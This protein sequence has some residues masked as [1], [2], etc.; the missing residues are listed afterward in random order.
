MDLTV[1][2]S[3]EDLRRR[4]GTPTYERADGYVRGGRVLS[5]MHGLDSDGD[6]A[7]RGQ[8]Q[9]SRGIAYDA[10]VSAGLDGDGVWFASR[11]DCPMQQGCKHVVALLMTVRAAQEREHT[12]VG[13]GDERR[14]ERQLSS[15]LDELDVAV[16]WAGNGTTTKPLA[17]QVDLH[18]RATP[19]RWQVPTTMPNRGALRIRPLQRGARDNWVKSGASFQDLPRMRHDRSLDPAQVA[20]LSEIAAVH[21]A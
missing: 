8:V 17:L 13:R 16:D 6:L 15:V 3:D 5:C 20:V 2:L 1:L 14:W 10:Y 12:A 7:I 19:P 9:G 18:R 21:Q 4:F 11:C